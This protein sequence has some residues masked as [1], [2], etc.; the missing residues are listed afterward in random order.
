MNM[1]SLT[2]YD[3]L[4]IIVE[5]GPYNAINWEVQQKILNKIESGQ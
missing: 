4:Q 5:Q 1:L 3:G 2:F